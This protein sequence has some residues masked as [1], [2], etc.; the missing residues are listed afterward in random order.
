MPLTPISR[1]DY[2]APFFDAAAEGRL[3]LRRSADGTHWAPPGVIAAAWAG[4]DELSWAE[5]EGLGEVVTWTTIPNREDAGAGTTVALIELVEGP[6]LTVQ[7][8]NVAPA[9]LRVGFPIRIVFR[10]PEGGEAVPVA[11]PR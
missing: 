11:V 6:W 1:D 3:L 8:Q 9:E 7:V 10:R 2:S 4:A 5:A